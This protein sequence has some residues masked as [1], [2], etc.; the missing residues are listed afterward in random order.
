MQAGRNTFSL[1]FGNAILCENIRQELHGKHSLL[2]VFSGDVLVPEFGGVLRVAIYLELFAKQ[3]GKIDISLSVSYNGKNIVNV[4]AEIH[5]KDLRDPAI[6]AT[7]VIPVHI[8]RP[9]SIVVDV[10]CNGNTRRCI[11][12]RVRASDTLKR[13]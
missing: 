2:G 5:Y 11:D 1:R 10:T 6:I 12:K 3:L 7:P 8:E 9:A 4:Q 13:L